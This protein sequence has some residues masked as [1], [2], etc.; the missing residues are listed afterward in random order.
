MSVQQML[1]RRA[2]QGHTFAK[3]DDGEVDY[4]AVIEVIAKYS[5]DQARGSDGR[6]TSGGSAASASA[7]TVKPADAAA[8]HIDGD[9]R[10]VALASHTEPSV[11]QAVHATVAAALQTLHDR[12]KV[13]AA[14]ARR[15]ITS[16]RLHDFQP[17]S[18][19][20]FKVTASHATDNP[21]SHLLSSVEVNP[22]HVAN[23][24]NPTGRAAAI[25]AVRSIGMAAHSLGGSVAPSSWRPF[26][27][28]HANGPQP[29]PVV[30]A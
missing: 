2:A 23:I 29:E 15:V 24:P 27:W 8:T 30:P 16:T 1:K 3:Q 10:A 6:W 19:G 25:A 22:F 7:E 28:T 26:N 9:A 4:S 21:G 14:K 12:V 13:Q 17:T 11:R 18:A 20:G 5:P